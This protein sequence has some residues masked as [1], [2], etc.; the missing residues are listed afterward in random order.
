MVSSLPRCGS[1]V[2]A[3][4][5]QNLHIVQTDHDEKSQGGRGFFSPSFLSSL[6]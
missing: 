3:E 4:R 6:Q 2:K 1:E 5:R